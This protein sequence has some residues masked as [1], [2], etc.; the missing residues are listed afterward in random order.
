MYPSC[1]LNEKFPNPNTLR[2]H[3]GDFTKEIIAGNIPKGIFHTEISI[4]PDLT[5]KE[6]SWIGTHHYLYYNHFGKRANFLWEPGK[7][8]ETLLQSDDFLALADFCNFKTNWGVFSRAPFKPHPHK[9]ILTKILEVMETLEGEEKDFAKLQLVNICST[10]TTLNKNWDNRKRFEQ[11]FGKETDAL[12]WNKHKHPSFYKV[13]LPHPGT[14]YSLFAPIKATARRK[15]FEILRICHGLG[16]TP[17]HIHTDGIWIQSKTLSEIQT[18]LSEKFG[19]QNQPGQLKFKEAENGLFL[20]PNVWWAWEGNTI[21]AKGVPEHKGLIFKTEANEIIEAYHYF[22][23]TKLLRKNEEETQWV[24]TPPQKSE[25]RKF[26]KY[27][28]LNTKIQMFQN[29]KKIGKRK[30]QQP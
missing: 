15:M 12:W 26:R 20:S 11:L 2:K 22:E 21:V 27:R 5:A 13:A 25:N 29:T 17:I 14:A 30:N 1:I 7:T 10:Q 24:R 9:E 8:I 16:A 4:K 18:A 28:T 3:Q 23:F 19:N 6:K